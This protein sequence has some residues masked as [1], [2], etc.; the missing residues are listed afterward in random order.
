VGNRIAIYIRAYTHSTE[1]LQPTER[2]NKEPIVEEMCMPPVPVAV[3]I[4]VMTFSDMVRSP[5]QSRCAAVPGERAPA[6]EAVA[7][8]LKAAP[9]RCQRDCVL[10]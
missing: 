9:G 3:P 8:R 4:S 10:S 5:I 2:I 1:R 7:G 6:P